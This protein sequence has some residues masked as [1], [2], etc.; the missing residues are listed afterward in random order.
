MLQAADIFFPNATEARRIA[1]VD[2]VEEAARALAAMG[3]IGRTDGGPIVA[4]KLGADGA[5][6]CRADGP[7]V[8]VRAMPIHSTDTTGAG[9]SFDAGFLQAWLD[10]GN[11]RES[12]ELGAVCGALS[13]RRSGGVDGQATLAEARMSLAAW[14]GE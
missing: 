4:L 5:L 13:T 2:D 14:A 3:S 1:Q 11:L 10:G 12:L 6:A 8:R 7:I 9:D